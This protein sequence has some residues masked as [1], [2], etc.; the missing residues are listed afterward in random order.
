V[1]G[2]S[3]RGWVR[4]AAAAALIASSGTA[5]VMAPATASA[6][7]RSCSVSRGYL[8]LTDP[9]RIDGNDLEFCYPGGGLFE[10]EVTISRLEKGTWVTLSGGKGTVTYTCN[11][12]AENE[13]NVSGYQLDDTFDAACG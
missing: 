5:A 7:P 9:A 13:Y 11:G 2:I 4:L 6:A 12:T 3:L 10:Y 1:L 8:I